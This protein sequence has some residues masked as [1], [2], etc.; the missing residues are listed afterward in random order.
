LVF[1]RQV[2]AG[3]GRPHYHP[4]PLQGTRRHSSSSISRT[5]RLYCG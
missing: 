3:E 5:T 2:S 1:T 4:E